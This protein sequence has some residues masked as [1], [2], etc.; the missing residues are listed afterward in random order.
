MVW[1]L[2]ESWS[3]TRG[4][5]ERNS[6]IFW[7]M[8]AAAWNFFKDVLLGLFK[9]QHSMSLRSWSKSILARF[10][11]SKFW[12]KWRSGPCCTWWIY[13]NA[14][15]WPDTCTSFMNWVKKELIKV[16]LILVLGVFW[17]KLLSIHFSLCGCAIPL[18]ARFWLRSSCRTSRFGTFCWR[19]SKSLELWTHGGHDYCKWNTSRGWVTR[20]I[21]RKK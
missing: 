5:R 13:G 8:S 16:S 10:R 7:K 1:R 4:I 2:S 12:R 19:K 15:Y 21:R 11:S 14:R 9:M 3:K 6:G 18:C 17:W 20:G